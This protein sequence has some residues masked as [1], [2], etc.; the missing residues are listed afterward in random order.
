[1]FVSVMWMLSS[2]D[3]MSYVKASARFRRLGSSGA[4]R[5]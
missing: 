2:T 1:M 4:I 3:C 5:N